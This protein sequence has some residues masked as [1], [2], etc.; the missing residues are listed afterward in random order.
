MLLVEHSH[1]TTH[2]SAPQSFHQINPPRDT[3]ATLRAP[4]SKTKGEITNPIKKKGWLQR[5][6]RGQ[7]DSERSLMCKASFRHLKQ[8]KYVSNLQ[9]YL[10]EI[11]L[12]SQITVITNHR[13]C[14]KHKCGNVW[15]FSPPLSLMKEGKQEPILINYCHFSVITCSYG[16]SAI[17]YI[18]SHQLTS[19]HACVSTY[20]ET[21][22]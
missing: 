18:Y 16:I 19:L 1:S 8:K 11:T 9:F 7:E 3:P 13:Y 6:Q 5:H 4:I 2:A 12:H 15:H 14:I 10:N 21:D 20:Y 17:N 22:K